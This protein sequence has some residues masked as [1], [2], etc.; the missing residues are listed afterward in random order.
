MIKLYSP[1]NEIQLAVL[2]S[3]FDAEDIP[4]FVHNDHFGSMRPGV[5]IELFNRKT[6][7][8][9]ERYFEK[10]CE[11]L[12]SYL[13]NLEPETHEISSNSYSASDKLRMVFEALVFGWIMPGNKWRRK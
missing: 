5:Q 2:R 1:E 11:I 8:V 12:R 3:I 7:M 13:E 4:I 6:I 9:P 10:S